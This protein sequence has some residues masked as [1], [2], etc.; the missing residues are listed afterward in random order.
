MYDKILDD[1]KDV[2][3][4]I[5]IFFEA[6][7]TERR[8]PSVLKK[9]YKVVWPDIPP[10]PNLAYGYNEFG[11][12]LGNA[13]A[14]EIGRYD[15]LIVATQIMEADDAKLIWAVAHSQ[16]RRERGPAWEKIGRLMGTRGATIK[17]R[18]ERAVLSFW[19]KLLAERR[20]SERDKIL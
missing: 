4:L 13:S 19:Y 1:A 8:L 5:E 14:V 15:R 10:D 11:P 6:A 16:V 9:R 3:G 2:D 12:A 18:F 7:L 17:R 20:V